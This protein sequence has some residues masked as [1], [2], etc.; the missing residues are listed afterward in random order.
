MPLPDDDSDEEEVAAGA[1]AA[2]ADP[3]AQRQQPPVPVPVPAP[4]PAVIAPAIVAQ[5]FKA[6]SFAAGASGKGTDGLV[7]KRVAFA[8]AA[9]AQAGDQPGF[10][11]YARGRSAP[12]APAATAAAGSEATPQKAADGSAPQVRPALRIMQPH[13]TKCTNCMCLVGW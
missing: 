4:Q 2:Q 12:P 9:P 1:E 5:P 11:G 13:Y 8:A 7:Q 10:S 6:S 3:W